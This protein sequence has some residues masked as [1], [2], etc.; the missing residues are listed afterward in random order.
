MEDSKEVRGEE[1]IQ[2]NSN[3][4]LDDHIAIKQEPRDDEEQ[5]VDVLEAELPPNV[6]VLGV[7][8][9]LNVALVDDGFVLGCN[10]EEVESQE[11]ASEVAAPSR[12]EIHDHSDYYYNESVVEVSVE[13]SLPL[14]SFVSDVV[15][16][17]IFF[18][19]LNT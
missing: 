15:M 14:M 13:K 16:F 19:I 2:E 1:G 9:E 4:L 11:I 3:A 8:E 18:L 5:E 10:E 12:L 6:E 17:Y 7:D